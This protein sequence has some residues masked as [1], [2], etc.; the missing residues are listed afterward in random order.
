MKMSRFGY[1]V[2]LSM[3]VFASAALGDYKIV[4]STIDGGGGQSSGGS[5]KA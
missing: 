3:M 5:Y 2:S 4:W 1:V